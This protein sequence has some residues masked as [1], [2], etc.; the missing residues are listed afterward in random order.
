MSDREHEASAPAMPLVVQVIA[1]CAI[2]AIVAVW[3]V[4]A[5]LLLLIVFILTA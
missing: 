3:P 5:W 1:A 4:Q 2:V